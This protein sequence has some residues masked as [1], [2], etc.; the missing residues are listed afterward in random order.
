MYQCI[1]CGKQGMELSEARGHTI[2]DPNCARLEELEA[3]SDDDDS[4][5]DDEDE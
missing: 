1:R 3:M 5:Q 4:E 2:F